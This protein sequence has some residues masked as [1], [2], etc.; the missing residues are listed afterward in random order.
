[1]KKDYILVIQTGY[2]GDLI[3]TSKF[4][5]DCK[6]AYPDKKIV[7]ICDKRF[8]SV[9][10]NLSENTAYDV[11]AYDRKKDSNP[12]NFIKFIFKFPYKFKFDT[13]FVLHGNKKVRVILAKLL[14]AKTVYDW[15]S[16]FKKE[17]YQEFVKNNPNHKKV[18]YINA[19]VLSL[20]TGK[21]TD[22]KDVVFSVPSD[23]QEKVD[24]EIRKTGFKNLIGINPQAGDN[25][26]CWDIKEFVCFCKMLVENGFTPVVTGVSKDGMDYVNA[27]NTDL[28]EYKDKILNLYDKTNFVELGAYYKRCQKV[29]SVDTGSAH[30]SYAVKTPTV[31]M[32]FKEDYARMW[33]PVDMEKNKFFDQKTVSAKEAFGQIKM[34]SV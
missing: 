19:D 2:F 9:V 12:V 20:V 32:F 22:D 7:F 4:L 21:Y 14:G 30:M 18:A 16:L 23:V 17:G 11:I 10:K 3:L 26:K 8:V 28:A 1:M 5:N 13:G 31:M 29:F 6:N 27:L 34:A 33:A 24:E 15:N 25:W